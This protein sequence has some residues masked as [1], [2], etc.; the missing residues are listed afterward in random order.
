MFG[1]SGCAGQATKLPL[2]IED[3]LALINMQMSIALKQMAHSGLP[4][5][6]TLGV[7]GLQE[8]FALLPPREDA[9]TPEVLSFRNGHRPSP[10]S[11]SPFL[12]LIT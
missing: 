11:I 12:E 7:A 4:V 10:N 2:N 9:G 3:T 8:A 1:G 5:A 6:V